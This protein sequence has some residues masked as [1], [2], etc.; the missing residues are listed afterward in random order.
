MSRQCLQTRV[1]ATATQLLPEDQRRIKS[2]M[3]DARTGEREMLEARVE[4]CTTRPLMQ[5]EQGRVESVSGALRLATG[6]R[7]S[8]AE[9][10][11]S[12]A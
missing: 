8:L 5:K 1:E 4:A 3:D 10:P 9:L 11:R 7:G 6:M 2:L 12:P